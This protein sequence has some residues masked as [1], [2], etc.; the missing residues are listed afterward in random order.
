MKNAV[1]GIDIGTS[2]VKV[3]CVYPDGRTLRAGRVYMSRDLYGWKKAL[4]GLL[5]EMDLTDVCAVGLSSQVGTYIIEGV[6]NPLNWYDSIGDTECTVWRDGDSPQTFIREIGMPHPPIRSYPLPRIQYIIDTYGSTYE[7]HPRRIC[8]P[9]DYLCW[10]FTGNWITDIYSMRGLA[11]P[12]GYY[13]RYFLDKL[14]ITEDHLPPLTM[15]NSMAGTVTESMA[16]VTGIAPGTPVYCGSND[17]YAGMLGLGVVNIGDAFDVTGTSEHIGLLQ[18]EMDPHTPLVVSPYLHT[19][20]LYGVTASSGS[21]LNFAIRN[22]GSVTLNL[23]QEPFPNAPLFLP[24]LNGERAPIWDG[25]ARGVYFGI[26]ADCSKAELAYS[27]LEGVTF[28]I[29]HIYENMNGATEKLIVGGGASENAFLNR[30]KA[31]MFGIPV[32]STCEKESSAL[33]G[34]IWA[35][36][37]SGLSADIN[38]AIRTYVKPNQIYE[39][40]TEWTDLLRSRFSVYKTL[41]PTLQQTF[42]HWKQRYT[43]RTDQNEGEN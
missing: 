39:P 12:S 23:L 3:L 8:Q 2:S 11:H 5:S 9:K 14:G 6:P 24:Y 21:S 22:Y 36:V 27:V 38:D 37:G 17:F 16:S 33:G 13:S 1:L 35:A 19:K 43:E 29:Y 15:P 20:V 28:S 4:L 7:G 26:N 40:I 31:S 10:L 34:A 32:I 25:N 41:Y 30:L 42:L 18:N